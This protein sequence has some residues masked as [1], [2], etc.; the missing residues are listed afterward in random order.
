MER[1]WRL[2]KP[3]TAPLDEKR[4]ILY[5][6]ITEHFNSDELEDLVVRMGERPDFV[7]ERSDTLNQKALA[8]VLWAQNRGK[9]SGLVELL[10]HLRPNIDWTAV[11]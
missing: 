2:I 3:R 9:Q 6:L 7:F 4:P 1:T 8:I 10:K 5:Q 11:K